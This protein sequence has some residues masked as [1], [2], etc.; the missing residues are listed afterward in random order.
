MWHKNGNR[1]GQ[2]VA[3][4]ESLKSPITRASKTH[5]KLHYTTI[6]CSKKYLM[7][8]AVSCSTCTTVYQFP[9]FF[10]IKEMLIFESPGIFIL[11]PAMC[12]NKYLFYSFL[13]FNTET[14]THGH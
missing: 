10:E 11:Y 13:P 5:F 7:N 8:L 12:I 9:L 14:S 4:H 3:L 1:T 6:V 2:S